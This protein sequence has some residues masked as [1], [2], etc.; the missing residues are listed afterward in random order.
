MISVARVPLSAIRYP[1]SVGC[2]PLE[3]IFAIFYF[4]MENYDYPQIAELICR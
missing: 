4:K 2:Q 1:L 3:E